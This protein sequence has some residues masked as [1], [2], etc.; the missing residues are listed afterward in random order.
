[1][2]THAS[3]AIS[4][5]ALL[6]AVFG[7]TPIGE[8]A[9][10]QVIPRNSVGTPQLKRNAVQARQLAPN[11]VRSAHVLN[12]SLLAADFRTGQLPQGA[13]GEKGDKGAKGDT[14]PPGLAGLEV[15]TAE[16]VTDSGRFK[17]AIA[18]CPSGKRAVGGGAST[19]A[20]ENVLGL[21]LKRSQPS[22]NPPSGWFAQGEEVLATAQNWKLEVYAV[23]ANVAS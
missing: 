20:V 1:M 4:I 7:S 6:V 18:V 17:S 11:A 9:W 19:L 8:A 3:I 5:T 16:S 2:R 22:G 14:G 23:C 15:V 21:G 10:N 13:K 12:G